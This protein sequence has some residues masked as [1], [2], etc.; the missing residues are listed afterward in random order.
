VQ[1]VATA[2]DDPATARAVSDILDGL[3]RYVA[4]AAQTI[5]LDEQ[6][7]HLA[8]QPSAA[9]LAQYRQATDLLKA[10]LLP[11]A[12]SL[13]DHNAQ[14]LERTY[15]THARAML[16][17]LLPSCHRKLPPG[18]RPRTSCALPDSTALDPPIQGRRPFGGRIAGA[19]S[20]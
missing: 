4:L 8:G 2:T 6:A 14:T 1:T 15:Q 19:G 5:P 13:T 10:T 17:L 18:G 7:N 3:G 11:A 20:G 16:G 9:T 12:R